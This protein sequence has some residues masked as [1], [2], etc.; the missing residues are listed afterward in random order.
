MTRGTT[1]IIQYRFKK[2]NVTDLTVAVLTI[3]QACKAI[4]KNL[5]TAIINAEDNIIGWTLTQE[6]TLGFIS[7]ENAEVQLRW[8]IGDL[9]GASAIKRVSI[10]A[11]LKEGV[12]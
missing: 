9:A 6:E 1:P 3:K 11:I 8:K 7:E 12:V 2:N 5:D 4:E 10:G